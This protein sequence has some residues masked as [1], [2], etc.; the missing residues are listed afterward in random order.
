MVLTVRLEP[1]LEAR[2]DQVSRRKGVSKSEWVRQALKTQLESEARPSAYEL[3]LKVIQE[4][5]LNET[6][7]ESGPSDLSARHREM[8]RK[9]LRAKHRR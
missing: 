4:A 6:P 5:G 2:I 8:L 1:E 9:K 7:G 3:Y